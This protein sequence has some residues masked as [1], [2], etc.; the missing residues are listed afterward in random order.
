MTHNSVFKP[1]RRHQLKL[2]YGKRVQECKRSKAYGGNLLIKY[3]QHQLDEDK[4][5]EQL[6]ISD[7]RAPFTGG[8]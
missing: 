5:M 1:A 8:K 3:T 6:K 4:L 2:T 7:P